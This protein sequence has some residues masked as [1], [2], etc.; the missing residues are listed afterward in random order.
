MSAQGQTPPAPRGSDRV[1]SNAESGYGRA[2][3]LMFPRRAGL[4]GKAIELKRLGAGAEMEQ[5]ASE[6]LARI[7]A[8]DYGAALREAGAAPARIRKYAV[9]VR[10]KR[11]IVRQ[12]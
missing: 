6:A 12:G 5:G 8:R 9:A 1:V 11:V 10:G 3:I 2:D 4:T 7:E